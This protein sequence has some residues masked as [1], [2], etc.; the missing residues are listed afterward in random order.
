VHSIHKKLQNFVGIPESGPRSRKRTLPL[1]D[2]IQEELENI[3]NYDR[4]LIK[5]DSL[6]GNL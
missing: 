2:E 3:G 4:P 1:K 5:I 6:E